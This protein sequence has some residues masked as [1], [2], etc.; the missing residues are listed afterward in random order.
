MPLTHPYEDVRLGKNK[1]PWENFVGKCIYF[2]KT[3]LKHGNY[4]FFF[5]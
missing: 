3:N 2:L 4:V 1:A 5:N